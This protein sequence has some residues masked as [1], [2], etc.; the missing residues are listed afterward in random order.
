MQSCHSNHGRSTDV[1]LIKLLGSYTYDINIFQCTW[2][3]YSN[4]RIVSF[5]GKSSKGYNEAT[6]KIGTSVVFHQSVGSTNLGHDTIHQLNFQHP[7]AA[8][9]RHAGSRH[10]EDTLL[11]HLLLALCDGPIR[12]CPTDW[13]VPKRSQLTDDFQ[14][15]WILGGCRWRKVMENDGKLDQQKNAC[16]RKWTWSWH[17]PLQGFAINRTDSQGSYPPFIH[18]QL[19]Q[20]VSMHLKQLMFALER[21]GQPEA[22]GITTRWM[23]DFFNCIHAF[24]AHLENMLSHLCLRHPIEWNHHW[25]DTNSANHSTDKGEKHDLSGH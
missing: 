8:R 25:I 15:F 7:N 20:H 23:E 5:V 17:K 10:M 19:L 24:T 18:A 4:H 21:S 16:Q 2:D 1:G 14:V 13:L 3:R 22:G 9:T 6:E 11:F 12:T